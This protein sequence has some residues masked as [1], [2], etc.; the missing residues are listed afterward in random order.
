M[1]CRPRSPPTIPSSWAGDS[2]ARGRRGPSRWDGHGLRVPWHDGATFIR[3]GTPTLCFG[4]GAIAGPCT[5]FNSPRPRRRPR[6]RRRRPSR[7][8]SCAGVW[9]SVMIVH[10]SI[11]TPKPGKE[12]DLID[13]DAPVW[14]CRP[15]Q[16]GFDRARRTLRDKRSGRLDRAW[17]AGRTRRRGAPASRPCAP[18]SRT[19]RSTSGRRPRSRASSSRRS[20]GEGASSDDARHKSSSY[21]EPR[22]RIVAG[23]VIARH[24]RGGSCRQG[25]SDHRWVVRHRR[26][27]RARRRAP[28]PATTLARTRPGRERSPRAT[29]RPASTAG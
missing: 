8:S 7:W 4:P 22:S 9:V 3:A 24:H 15:G 26:R 29:C 2:C 20:D 10:M 13:S 18:P 17:R 12:Q 28:A 6:L 16:P 1:S 19:T 23:I 14:R 27:R 5:A 21:P 11:H 25:R